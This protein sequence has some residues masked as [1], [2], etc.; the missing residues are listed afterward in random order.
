MLRGRP[1]IH[2]AIEH[3]Y[4]LGFAKDIWDKASLHCISDVLLDN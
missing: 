1:Y 4:T 3:N 2:D